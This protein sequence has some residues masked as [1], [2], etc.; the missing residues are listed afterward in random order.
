M[1]L[2]FWPIDCSSFLK[3][4]GGMDNS[5]IKILIRKA[6]M[7][8]FAISICSILSACPN[9]RDELPLSSW[10]QFVPIAH[11]DDETFTFAEDFSFEKNKKELTDTDKRRLEIFLKNVSR[12]G[13]IEEV[14]VISWI[15][16]KNSNFKLQKNLA[17]ERASLLEEEIGAATSDSKIETFT[18]SESKGEE[19]MK[20]I[21]EATLESLHSGES[22]DAAT[23][24]IVLEK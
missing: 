20:E 11:A 1:G 17:E 12:L 18:F 24:M 8:V 10:W 3:R 23:V 21:S 13:E 14:K 6:A 9:K 22:K 4:G 19:R 2:F 15:K 5:K 7:A 16:D